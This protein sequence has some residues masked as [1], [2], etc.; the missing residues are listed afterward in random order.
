MSIVSFFYSNNT[1]LSN[2][3]RKSELPYAYINEKKEWK[4]WSYGEPI[5]FR[6]YISNNPANKIIITSNII[7][8]TIMDGYEKLKM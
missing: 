1:I 7:T 3:V 6:I 2:L 4:F 8:K 5:Q